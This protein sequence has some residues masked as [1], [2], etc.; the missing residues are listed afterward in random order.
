MIRYRGPGYAALNVTDLDRSRHWYE[1]MMG[2]QV[3][4]LSADGGLML[5]A[6]GQ[7]AYSLLLYPAS[8]PGMKRA[9]WVLESESQFE[10]LT[11]QLD[12]HG[13]AW[14]ELPADERA[15][16]HLG[17]TVRMVEP[18]TGLTLDF[19]AHMD[20][21]RK[22]FRPTVAKL[23]DLCHIGIGA[24]RYREAI[25]FY[26]DVLNFKTSDE[27]DG[28]INLMRCF[29]NPL[30]HSF[31]LAATPRNTLHH[32]NFM[33]NDAADMSAA[34]ERFAANAVP[35]VWD[36]HHPPS[37]NTFLFF[38]DPDGLSLEYGHGMELF[39][40][41]GARD[42]RVFPARPESFDSTGATRDARTAAVGEIETA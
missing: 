29:P 19:Y 18:V 34:R 11:A 13:V 8:Q 22:P 7:G 24:A 20:A 23:Q 15:G 10:V 5:N 6:G 30:H 32:L 28:R 37:G 35:I 41:V 42:K 26:E 38:L 36:G 31:A 9:G 1:T 14:R 21:A 4:G 39:P 2:A 33:V 12:R 27:I 3:E 16:L 25:R 40:E 17:R